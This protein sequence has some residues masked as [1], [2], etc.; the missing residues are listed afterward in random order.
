M[1]EEENLTAIIPEGS[2]LPLH[3]S[4]EKYSPLPGQRRGLELGDSARCP[5]STKVL[6]AATAVKTLKFC[7]R[8]KYPAMFR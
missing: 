5:F 4:R 3:F 6:R 2:R 1:S 8:Y 7:P